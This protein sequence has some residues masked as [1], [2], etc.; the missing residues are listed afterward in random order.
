MPSTTQA[1]RSASSGH[2]SPADHC[3]DVGCGDGG[4]SGGWLQA[5]A[6]KYLGVD[7]SESA[8]AVARE[9]GLDVEQ[10]G[11]AAELPVRRRRP[12]IV[13]CARRS[14]STCSSPRPPWQRY[15]EFFDPGGE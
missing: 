3:L 4:T 11:D 5:H 1:P 14:S 10:I 15:I 2:V 7:I 6:A 8:L 13:S 12:S 9:R